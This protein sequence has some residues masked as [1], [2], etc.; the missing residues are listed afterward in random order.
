M[1]HRTGHLKLTFR[2]FFFLF[3]SLREARTT[4]LKSTSF[5]THSWKRKI[6]NKLIQLLKILRI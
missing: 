2:R 3:I 1:V 4:H 5:F 6:S